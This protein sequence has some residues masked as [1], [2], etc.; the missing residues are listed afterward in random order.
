LAFAKDVV[1]AAMVYGFYVDPNCEPMDEV[2]KLKKSLFIGNNF[3]PIC[4]E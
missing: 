3:Y 1:K 2:S 4:E